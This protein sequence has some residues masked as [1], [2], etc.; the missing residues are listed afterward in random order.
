MDLKENF[1]VYDWYD[2]GI[3][4]TQYSRSENFKSKLHGKII[5]FKVEDG[6]EFCLIGSANVTPEGLGLAGTI[7]SNTE[8]SLLIKAE[9]GQLLDELG[10][11]LLPAKKKKLADFSSK[12][13]SPIYD[14]IIKNNRFSVQLLSAEYLYHE[15]ILFSSGSFSGEFQIIF[16]DGSNKLAHQEIIPTYEHEIKLSLTSD[17]SGYQYVQFAD[18]NGNFISNK[19]IVSDYFLLAKTHPNPQTEEIERLYSEI[20]NGDLSK[21]LDLL[22]FAIIDESEKDDSGINI[23]VTS[24]KTREHEDRKEPEQLYDLSTYKPL[25]HTN[26]EKSLLL[27]SPTL[28]ILDVL[29]FIQN[30]GITSDNQTDIRGDE[31]ETDI[32]SIS[33]NEANEVKIVHYQSHYTL[34]SERRKLLNYINNLFNYQHNILYGKSP[35]KNY[36]LTLTDLTRYL[37]FLELMLEYGG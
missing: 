20:Q 32:G 1:I 30:R 13:D 33:G 12:T 15:L 36:A 24:T 19:L 2:V 22:H 11:K 3:S 10:I 29:R 37:I 17:I 6:K 31:Q 21:I 35:I 8:V 34:G 26:F 23:Q 5:H 27:T 25:L 7:K 28:R 9:E 4:R 14:T 18:I 16:F